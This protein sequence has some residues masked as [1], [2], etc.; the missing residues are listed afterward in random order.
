M[1]Q[2]KRKLEASNRRLTHLGSE[3]TRS[4]DAAICRQKLNLM[5]RELSAQM[6]CLSDQNAELMRKLEKQK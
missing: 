4:K 2:Y 1:S 6:V 3:Y 5:F